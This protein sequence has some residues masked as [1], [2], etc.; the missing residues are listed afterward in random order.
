MAAFLLDVALLILKHVVASCRV[1]LRGYHMQ[2]TLA[3]LLQ[4]FAASDAKEFAA[5][6]AAPA[7][8]TPS[9]TGMWQ[10]WRRIHGKNFRWGSPWANAAD[11]QGGSEGLANVS[12]T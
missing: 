9:A 12:P 1:A 8:H 3:P 7:G 11:S 4:W 2:H 6:P 10:P 5:G